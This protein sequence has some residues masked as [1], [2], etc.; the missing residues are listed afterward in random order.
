M[1]NTSSSAQGH[2]DIVERLL[3]IISLKEQGIAIEDDSWRI[4]TLTTRQYDELLTRLGQDPDLVH[5]WDTKVRHDWE[6]PKL[7]GETGRLILRDPP[8]IHTSF[9]CAMRDVLSDGIK[10]LAN[11]LGDRK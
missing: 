1:T 8:F 7:E 11:R 6:P 10:E 5:F 3:G 2:R 9:L 4:Y